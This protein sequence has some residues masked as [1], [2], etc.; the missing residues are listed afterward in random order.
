MIRDV[1]VDGDIFVNKAA[2]A[3]VKARTT[4]S[5]TI[6]QFREYMDYILHKTRSDHEVAGTIFIGIQGK[7]NYRYD[8]GR[9]RPYK[10]NRTKPKPPLLGELRE[11]AVD[12]Y[13]AV[14]VDKIETDDWLGINTYPHRDAILTS[15]KDLL[16]VP[17]LHLRLSG[18][19]KVI[20]KQISDVEGLQNFY[21]SMLVGDNSDNILGCPGVG[22]VTAEKS[23]RYDP[24]SMYK[25]SDRRMYREV[26]RQYLRWLNRAY[27]K[28]HNLPPSADD[29]VELCDVM[30]NENANLLWIQRRGGSFYS[31]PEELEYMV[32]D[33]LS[34]GLM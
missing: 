26:V 2:F 12:H 28:E 9:I 3:A 34:K 33:I 18:S 16:Q 27:M 13:G 23:I 10:G 19:N 30:F 1:Y 17:G 6:T 24:A 15:D 31:P 7:G 29:L 25:E 22:I 20:F 14:V 5:Q 8:L 21:I 32:R 11:Y 4:P